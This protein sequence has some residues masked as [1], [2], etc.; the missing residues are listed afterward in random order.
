MI[1]AAL[2]RKHWAAIGWLA[3]VVLAALSA[4][5]ASPTPDL[6]NV[7]Q[8]PFHALHWLG[9]TP[10][11]LDVGLSL[12]QGARTVLLVSLP[13]SI[14]TLLLGAALGGAAGYWGNTKWRV[15]R[16][17]LVGVGITLL[18]AVAALFYVP[19]SWLWLG[20]PLLLGGSW[21]LGRNHHGAT[22][23]IPV[24]SIVMA[25]IALLNSIPLLVLVVATAAVRPPSVGGV[26]ALLSLTCWPVPARLMRGATLQSSKQP[27]LEAAWAAGIP[28]HRILWRHIGPNTLPVLLVRFP[29]TVA[30]LIG[31]ETTLSFLGVGLPADTPSWGRLLATV[32]QAPTNWWLIVCP[33]LAVVGTVLSLQR[34]SSPPKGPSHVT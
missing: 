7:N 34:L 22:W 1:Y 9:T 30:I 33:G 6:A 12:W 19:V 13:A 2:L 23:P 20:G 15:G 18:L 27:Y 11:G 24:D 26:V 5:T 17:K 32:R 14:L 31:L 16:L 4:P 28:T 25:L 10:Q 29:L 8:P 3:L 21:L